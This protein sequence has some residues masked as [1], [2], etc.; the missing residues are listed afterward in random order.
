[1]KGV[2]GMVVGRRGEG[3]GSVVG[4]TPGDALKSAPKCFFACPVPIAPISSHI[5]KTIHIE[6]FNQQFLESHWLMSR[7]SDGW[8]VIFII[9]RGALETG[10]FGKSPYAEGG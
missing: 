6:H 2:C 4:A 7:I 3:V 5:M 9:I 8:F 10:R 1:M